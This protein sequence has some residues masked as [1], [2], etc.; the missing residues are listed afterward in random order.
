MTTT[1]AAAT[2]A[3]ISTTDVAVGEWR[4]RTHLAGDPADPAILWLHGSGPGVSALS[5]WQTLITTMPGYRHIAPDVL[6]FGNSSHPEDLPL[7]VAGSAS[8]RA[9]A[10]EGLL[11]A[12]GVTRAHLVGNSMGGMIALLMLKSRPERFDRVILMG[13]GG[14]PMTPTPDLIAMITY[15]ND[16]GDDSMRDLIGRFVFDTGL[17][18]DELGA[19]AADRAAV[20]GRG[21]V[22]RS[23]LRTFSP[24]GPP[25]VFAEEELGGIPHEVLLVHGREDRIIPKHASFYLADALPNAQL[26]VLPHAGHWVQIEQTERFRALAQQF[27]AGTADG[28]AA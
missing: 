28:G 12:L 26:H 25:L 11:D 3:T 5:N 4:I 6:G 8:M 18:G 20:A 15:Y 10:M 13:S 16:P 22:R 21:D 7:G 17:F 2:A 19:I 1:R 27:L 9:A 14:A 23:H 24:D